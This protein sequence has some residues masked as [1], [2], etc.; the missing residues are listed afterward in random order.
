V[1]AVLATVGSTALAAGIY[2]LVERPVRARRPW[3]TSHPWARRLAAAIQ[4]SLV[5]AGFAYWLAI[6]GWRAS[7]G[8]G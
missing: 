1:A 8:S 3:V 5:P 7:F 4:V 2:Y 6:G